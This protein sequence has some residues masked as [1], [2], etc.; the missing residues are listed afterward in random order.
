VAENRH[1]FS[2]PKGGT[3]NKLQTDHYFSIGDSHGIEGKPCQDYAISGI[4]KDSAF[5]IVSDGC[6]SG[7]HTDI[8]ARMMALGTARAIRR[9]AKASENVP[10]TVSA[11]SEISFFQQAFLEDTMRLLEV[12]FED[13]LATCIYAY[14]GKDFGFV[15][16]LGDGVVAFVLPS[17]DLEMHLFEWEKNMP[18]YPVYKSLTGANAFVVAHGRDENRKCLR[19]E[20]WIRKVTGEYVE[21]TCVEH[22]VKDGMYGVTIPIS[23]QSMGVEG[24][25]LGIF[26]DGVTQIDGIGQVDGVD[27][28]DAVSSFLAFKTTGG[29]FLKRR[30]IRGLKE[31]RKQEKTLFDDIGCAALCFAKSREESVG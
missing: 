8:G 14:V 30:M 19:E 11:V 31:F 28:K 17:G 4:L 27:W 2:F 25:T 21:Q 10:I 5:A 13:M 22:S 20:I 7:G 24:W 3:V 26:S 29:A 16:V 18:F 12:P 23:T 1:P 15:H 9:H 6:S